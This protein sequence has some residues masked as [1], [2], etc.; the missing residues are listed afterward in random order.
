[1]SAEDEVLSRFYR[2][3]DA[4]LGN[5]VDTLGALLA[6]DYRGYNLHVGL[7]GRELILQAYSPGADSCHEVALWHQALTRS[8]HASAE[9]FLCLTYSPSLPTTC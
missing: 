2:F 1:M 3:R 8:S 9:K 7:E 4:L 5:D 6:P